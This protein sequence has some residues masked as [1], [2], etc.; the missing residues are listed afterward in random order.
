MYIFEFHFV[1]F[2]TSKTS[3]LMKNGFSVKNAVS[4]G[5]FLLQ[6]KRG[7]MRS[8]ILTVASVSL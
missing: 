5:M 3:K 6:Q 4:G 1:I 7:H 2:T 8:Y